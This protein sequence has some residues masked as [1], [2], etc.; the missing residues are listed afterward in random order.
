MNKEQGTF[1]ATTFND[2]KMTFEIDGRWM[3]VNFLML[4]TEAAERSYST[5]RAEIPDHELAL[6]INKSA[7]LGIARAKEE[8]GQ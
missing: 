2:G 4:V 1:K 8:G 7:E 6:F 3:G 5:L